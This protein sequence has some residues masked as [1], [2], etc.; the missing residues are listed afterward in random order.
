MRLYSGGLI[1]GRTF[2]SEIWE[3]Y[4]WEGLFIYLF[5]YLL[6]LFF[7]GEGGAYFRNFTVLRC[8]Q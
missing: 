3:V 7:G 1:I 8:D 5:I 4:L 6:L 2:A